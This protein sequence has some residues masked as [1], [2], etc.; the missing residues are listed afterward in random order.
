MGNG[1]PYDYK[2]H[3]SQ[4]EYRKMYNPSSH[5]AFTSCQLAEEHLVLPPPSF[6]RLPRLLPCRSKS[7]EQRKTPSV[8]FKFL[9]SGTGE[10]RP[11]EA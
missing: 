7:I 11:S 3:G 1:H 5:L 8:I 9:Q 4:R 6:A 2:S 10:L